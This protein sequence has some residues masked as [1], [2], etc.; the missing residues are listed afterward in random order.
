MSGLSLSPTIPTALRESVADADRLRTRAIDRYSYAGDASHY[1]HVPEAV[2]IA[3][4]AA[5]VAA[6]LRASTSTLPVTFRS[7][8][9]SLSGQAS[10]RGVLV[11]TRRSFRRIEVLD[12]GA[13]VRVQPGATMRAVNARLARHG[14]R[15]GPDPASEVACT[16]GGVVANNSSGMA[17][18]TAEN[19]YRT[20]ESLVLVLPSGTIVDTGAP[21]A[22]AMLREREPELAAGLERLRD[23]VRGDAASVA[24][25]RRQFALKNT[26][27]YGVNAFLDFDAPAEILAHLVIGSEGTLAFV[28]EATFRTV[29]VRPLVSTA[30]AVFRTLDEATRSLPALVET[31]AATLELMDATSLRV[32]QNL[33]GVPGAILGFDVAAEAALLVEYHA[34]TADEL[35]AATASGGGV[36]GGF[37]LREAAT[38]STDASA[39]A[40]AWKFRKGLYASVAGARPAGTTALL[41]DVVVPVERLADTCGSLQQLFVRHGYDDSVIFGHA[42]DGNIHF[43]LTDRFGDA[44]SEQRYLDFTDD[45]VD[46]ILDARGNLKAEHGTGRVMAPYVRRQYGDEL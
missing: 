44:A 5:E 43:M 39:R 27:G 18:G 37:A 30:L 22:D 29:P 41:E 10:G 28:A 40:S 16:I 34:D 23:R 9:T 36:L 11:D 6:I 19:S 33:P 35:L 12:G 8:G 25:I 7:G 20:I 46:L 45:M 2:V 3:Q 15:L 38:F 31:G 4:D 1:L 13:R 42:K 24:L 32:G 26:M 14:R 17:C 21:D